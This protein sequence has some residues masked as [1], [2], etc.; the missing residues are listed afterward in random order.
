MKD[1]D[2]DSLVI[3]GLLILIMILFGVMSY[4]MLLVFLNR[5]LVP[6][7]IH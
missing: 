6:V 3:G 4:L 7:G 2:Y 1:N 5:P